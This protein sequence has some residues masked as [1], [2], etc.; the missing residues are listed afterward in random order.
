MGEHLPF[1]VGRASGVKIA[2]ADGR[3]ERGREPGFERFGG[4]DVV[5]A[6]DEDRRLAGCFEAFGVND[7]VS[8]GLDQLGFEPHRDE[9]VAD[10]L[11]GAAGVIVVIRLALTLGMRSRLLSW[12][13]N[14][15]RCDSR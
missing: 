15:S 11:G 6:V 7:R 9:V 4:L 12:S 14:A 5:M 10:E 13:S 1:V 8:L 3:F 2:V